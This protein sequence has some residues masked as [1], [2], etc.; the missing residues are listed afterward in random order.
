LPVPCGLHRVLQVGWYCPQRTRCLRTGCWRCDTVLT[1]RL[2]ALRHG[3][4]APAVGAA[5][6]HV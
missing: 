6:R 3:A 5:T 4:Y 1:H 2:L